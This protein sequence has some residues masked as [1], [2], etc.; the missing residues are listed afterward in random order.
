MMGLY[1]SL[2][3]SVSRRTREIGL[4]MSLGASHAAVARLVVGEAALLVSIGVALGLGMALFV[5]HPLAAFLVSGLD[6]SDPASLA[7]AVVALGAL[8]IIAACPSTYHAIRIN[9][10]EALRHE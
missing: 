6:T 10:T 7:G 4:R 5:T 9:P 3:F 1:G 2:W 8:S